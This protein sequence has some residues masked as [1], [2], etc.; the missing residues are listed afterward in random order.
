MTDGHIRDCG[1][2]EQN[3]NGNK[4]L[5]HFVIHT[6]AA[7]A[8]FARTKRRRNR[9]PNHFEA[10]EFGDFKALA[11][12]RSPQSEELVCSRHEC[13]KAQRRQAHSTLCCP[14][15][16]E[17][18]P[19][20]LRNFHTLPRPWRRQRG[21]LPSEA[22]ST[23]CC[24]TPEREVS[25][26]KVSKARTKCETAPVAPRAGG[27]PSVKTHCSTGRFCLCGAGDAG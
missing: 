11:P 20:R 19:H 18:C 12:R 25:D 16:R 4:R 23:L 15:S 22:I 1:Q 7:A 8:A 13:R 27:K 26:N 5:R 9:N 10:T 21:T 3:S 6:G 17:R 14:T 24:A 2:A